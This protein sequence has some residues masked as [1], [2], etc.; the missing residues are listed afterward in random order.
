[1]SINDIDYV[2]DT[3]EHHKKEQVCLKNMLKSYFARYSSTKVTAATARVCDIDLDSTEENLSSEQSYVPTLDCELK[4]KDS[5]TTPKIIDMSLEK[6]KQFQELLNSYPM[7]IS[8]LP[9]ITTLIAHDIQLMSE[10]RLK[11]HLYHTSP[12]QLEYLKKKIR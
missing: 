2:I 10:T 9:S 8:D 7:I 3:P 12:A 5:D 1:M 6:E 4:V 11:L